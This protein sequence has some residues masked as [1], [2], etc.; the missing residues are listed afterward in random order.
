M[1]GTQ[2][3]A[4]AQPRGRVSSLG[5]AEPE[6]ETRPSL[7]NSRHAAERLRFSRS[8]GAGVKLLKWLLSQREQM[9]G[10]PLHCA[11]LIR[12]GFRL[13]VTEQQGTGGR[14]PAGSRLHTND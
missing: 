13:T 9:L 14:A 11:D 2:W 5:T 6:R 3:P 4:S 1:P 8:I 12:P 10:Y 7:D